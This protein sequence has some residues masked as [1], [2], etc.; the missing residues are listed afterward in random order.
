VIGVPISYNWLR[1]GHKNNYIEV[2]LGL[3]YLNE[4]REIGHS[5][6]EPSTIET[7]AFVF[8]TPKA[9]YRYQNPNGGFFFRATFTPPVALFQYSTSRFYNYDQP[10]SP[11]RFF[12]RAKVPMDYM[13]FPWLGVS[14]GY[15]L[16]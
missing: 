9:G 16:K 4:T 8:F 2:G 5:R 10:D 14:F 11:Y 7:D 13:A 15:T 3:T 12:P 1:Q 6:G